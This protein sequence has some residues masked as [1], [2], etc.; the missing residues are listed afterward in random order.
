[1]RI[2]PHRIDITKSLEANATRSSKAVDLP[3]PEAIPLSSTSTL[4]KRRC[5]P[6]SMNFFEEIATKLVMAIYHI[7]FAVRAIFGSIN[8]YADERLKTALAK[9]LP[10][11]AGDMNQEEWAKLVIW[12][13]N[14]KANSDQANVYLPLQLPPEKYPYY[15]QL[16]KEIAKLIPAES[17]RPTIHLSLKGTNVKV[18]TPAFG[19]IG[20]IGPL[21]DATILHR[22]MDKI[23]KRG[24]QDLH[25]ELYSSPP[26]RKREFFHLI[27]HA[28][29]Y[30]ANLKRFFNQTTISNFCLLSN[31]G[32]LNWKLLNAW[33]HN[34]LIHLVEKTIEKLTASSDDQTHIL[35]LST[36]EAHQ[37]KLYEKFL[38]R[39]KIRSTSLSALQIVKTQTV[40][41]LIKA[42]Q[43]TKKHIDTLQTMLE[44]KIKKSPKKITH[45]LLGCT[46]LPMGLFSL[47]SKTS[48]E[49]RLQAEF[50]DTEEEFAKAITAHLTA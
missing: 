16:Q 12:A 20:G 26:P 10:K 49:K 17:H 28:W 46:E 6:C 34:R 48:L 11:W 36:L 38:R 40:I 7:Q 5:T 32:H 24:W 30:A 45:I 1:M 44:S 21:S 39:A 15:C 29:T 14:I 2:Y 47:Q 43:A 35:I 3:Y 42:N 23:G 9:A 22:T 33:S 18:G 27:K 41:D 31:S 37:G 50:I 4:T 25:I 13:Y 8:T 19:M